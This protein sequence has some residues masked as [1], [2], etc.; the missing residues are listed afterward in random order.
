MVKQFMRYEGP[1]IR[2]LMLD[3]IPGQDYWV[4]CRTLEACPGCERIMATV[5]DNKGNNLKLYYAGY[6]EFHERWREYE[7]R[8][9]RGI[10]ISGPM[11]GRVDFNKEA[12]YVAYRAFIF[13]QPN[14]KELAI[15]NPAD[16]IEEM[17]DLPHEKAIRKSLHELTSERDGMPVYS[18]LVLLDG[19][20]ESKGSLAELY[21]ALFSGISVHVF[22]DYVDDGYRFL[23]KHAI[24]SNE[25]WAA[26]Q[27]I[28]DADKDGRLP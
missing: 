6:E 7:R 10:Y 21:A 13:T 18:H 19:W 28:R 2:S 24:S 3:A 8:K 12:F 27:K 9:V 25:V 5:C 17:M 26:V 20:E 14:A 4:S 1:L 15:Y 22:S 16:H 11:T 23:D